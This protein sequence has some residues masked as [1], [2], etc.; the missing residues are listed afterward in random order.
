MFADHP[1]TDDPFKSIDPQPQS[2][3][4]DEEP[5]PAAQDMEGNVLSL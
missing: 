1:F 5:E 3:A 4:A 2:P